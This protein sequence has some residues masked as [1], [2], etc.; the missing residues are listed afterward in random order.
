MT[1]AAQVV[2]ESPDSIKATVPGNAR[3]G[4]PQG[5]RHRK[6]TAGDRGQPRPQARV[7]R[8]GKSP[9]RDG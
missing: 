3:R 6:Q 8:W 2:E 9:P 4:Q 7:K 5:K 1:A